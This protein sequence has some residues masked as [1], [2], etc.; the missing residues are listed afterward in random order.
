MKEKTI[1]VTIIL[2]EGEFKDGTNTRIIEGLATACDIQ[3]NGLPEK[4]SANVK[5]SNL[6][7]DD[8][9]QMTFLAF[10]PLQ[11]RKNHIMI[12]AGNK[13][14]ELSLCFK[15]DITSAYPDFSTAPDVV[16]NIEAITAGWS[17]LLNTSPTSV[18]GEETAEK[19]IKGFA[20]ESGFSFFNNGVTDSVRN[21][22]YNGSPPDKARQCANEVNCEL[23]MDDE[24]W[25]IQPWGKTRGDAVVLNPECGLIGYPSFT[26]EGISCKCFFNPALKLGG[27]VKIESIV[28][29]ASGYWKITRLSHSLTAYTQGE[30]TS[31]IDAIWLKEYEGQEDPKI[32]GAT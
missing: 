23:L 18:N 19:L 16:F 8:M 31:S 3:K 27:Q 29:R 2:G 22:T 26:S 6:S 4:N 5:I 10:R 9:E 20:S 21:T 30:W 15:G 12:E 24:E 17:V 28:P 7:M 14:E 1:K 13:G 32:E 11:S 25:T